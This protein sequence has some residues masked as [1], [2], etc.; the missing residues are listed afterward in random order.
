MF[1]MYV[2]GMI[3]GCD[4][5]MDGFILNESIRFAICVESMFCSELGTTI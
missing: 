1:C 4:E 5:W 2:C 3:G